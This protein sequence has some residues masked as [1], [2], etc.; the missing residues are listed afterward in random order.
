MA[1]VKISELNKKESPSDS[2]ILV[3]VDDGET[4]KIPI[5]YF[6]Q[7][8][9]DD[10]V[11][12]TDDQS[13]YGKKGFVEG[14]GTRDIQ[15]GDEGYI[16]ADA[17][18]NVEITAGGRTLS[19]TQNYTL[20]DKPTLANKITLDRD[21]Q[22]IDIY[23]VRAVR[24]GDLNSDHPY[25]INTSTDGTKIYNLSEV[26]T[27]NEGDPYMPAG[28]ILTSG[29]GSVQWDVG[30]RGSVLSSDGTKII[31]SNGYV[32]GDTFYDELRN[33]AAKEHTHEEY[34]TG[35][36]VFDVDGVATERYVDDEISA[37]LGTILATLNRI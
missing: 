15:L 2:A 6:Q 11:N 4:V 3:G 20:I 30:A 37:T 13:I 35:D 22:S 26:Y 1:N 29:N 16:C 34:L 7:N 14:I 12:L 10:V 5:S 24:M 31:W 8:L 9:S 17:D 33:Y 21:T 23:S 27:N 25:G 36:T 18:D 19:L 32:H 28:A